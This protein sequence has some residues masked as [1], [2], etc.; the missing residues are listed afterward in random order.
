MAGGAGPAL[1]QEQGHGGVGAQGHQGKPVPI[2]H[3]LG[4][5]ARKAWPSPKQ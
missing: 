5:P 3:S 2:Y 1:G 4:A